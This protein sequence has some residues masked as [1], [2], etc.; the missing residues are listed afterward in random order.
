MKLHLAFLFCHISFSMLLFGQNTIGVID[1]QPDLVEDGYT[2][3]YPHNQPNVYLLDMC[4]EVVHTWTNADTLRPGNVAYLQENGDIVLT[5][6]PQIFAND[7]IWAGGGGATV[8][9]RTWDNEVLWSYTLN[10]STGRLHH[11]IEVKPDGNVFAIAWE[12]FSAAE[13]LEA[14][15]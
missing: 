8:E 1:F 7:P 11:D 13:A 5:Y 6:R 10:D 15:P 12:H 3:V 2:L 9:R 4:G 14:G